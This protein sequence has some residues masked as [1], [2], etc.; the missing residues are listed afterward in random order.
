MDPRA[1]RCCGRC[2]CVLLLLLCAAGRGTGC[3]GR[4][5]GR[6]RQRQGQGSIRRPPRAGDRDRGQNRRRKRLPRGPWFGHARCHRCGAQ[7]RRRPAHER[8]VQGRPG[9]ACGRIARGDRPAPLPGPARDGRGPDGPRPGAAQERAHRPRALSRIA[10]AGLDRQ[11]AVRH[12]GGA[13]PAVRG[14][15]QDRPGRDRYGQAPADLL[16]GH[17]AGRRAP[18]PAPGRRRQHRTRG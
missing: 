7:P 12:A 11:A 9:G 3:A 15:R 6:P 13:R 16:Q 14:H 18:R 17:R 8:A 2:G 4:H 5:Q 1:A 10:A